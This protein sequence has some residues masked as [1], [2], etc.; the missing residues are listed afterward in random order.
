MRRLLSHLTFLRLLVYAGIALPGSSPGQISLPPGA[1]GIYTPSKIQAF[2]SSCPLW[3][4]DGGFQSTIRLTNML[5]VANMSATV[6]LYMADG[7][8]YP[9]APAK[10]PAS[11]VAVINV[12]QALASAP[13]TIAKH[14][15]TFGS[16]TMTYNW[17]WQ[18]AVMATM[19]SLDTTRSL[20]Y[21]Y[22]FMFPGSPSTMSGPMTFQGLW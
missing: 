15:S 11:G 17:D 22:P 1:V 7:T 14:L 4:T 6:T 16:A 10:I 20:Q 5:A 9:L 21:V 2:V 3:R 19:S 8:P 18:G 13:A 12:N